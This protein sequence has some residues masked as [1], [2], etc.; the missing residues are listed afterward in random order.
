[1]DGRVEELLALAQLGEAASY[2]PR[3]LSG[4]MRRRLAYL[5]AVAPNPEILLLDE[6]FSSVDE[7]TRVGIHQVVHGITQLMDVTT[8]LVTHDLAEAVTLCDRVLILSNRP[9]KVASTFEI[10]FG[11]DRQMLELRGSPAYLE[12]YGQIW[13]ALSRQINASP[14]VSPLVQERGTS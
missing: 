4:G 14:A 9:A 10:P 1:L 13:Q 11:R 2:Y 12:L 8:V 6:P 3:Q 7:P 5:V